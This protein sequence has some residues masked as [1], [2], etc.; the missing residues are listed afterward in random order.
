[1]PDSQKDQRNPERRERSAL[2]VGTVGAIVATFSAAFTAEQA[3]IAQDQEYRS[4][5]AYMTLEIQLP[6]GFQTNQEPEIIVRTS[7]KG[8]TPV[9]DMQPFYFA[10]LSRFDPGFGRRPSE[11]SAE[12]CK[13]GKLG[14]SVRRYSFSESYSLPVEI[15]D[16]GFVDFWPDFFA[17]QASLFIE[18]YACYGDVFAETHTLR[19]CSQWDSSTDEPHQCERNYLGERF[20]RP[21]V[22]SA[23]V[24]LGRAWK[25]ILRSVGLPAD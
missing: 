25:G 21:D 17:G 13:Y 22:C 9:Y 2:L 4:L 12:A 15:S 3:C 6:K 10:Y 8:Q 24:F 7:S 19:F 20:D 18:G 5:R 16:N 1:M 23:R 14:S 11:E